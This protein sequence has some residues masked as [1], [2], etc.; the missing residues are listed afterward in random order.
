MENQ[1][2]INCRHFA[3]FEVRHEDIYEK[4]LFLFQAFTM[5]DDVLKIVKL[6]LII[7]LTM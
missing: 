5:F 2:F 4:L 6:L 7:F 3:V 1:M